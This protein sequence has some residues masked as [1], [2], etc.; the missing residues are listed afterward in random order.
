ML[1][2]Q[3]VRSVYRASQGVDGDLPVL[4]PDFIG[5]MDFR[6]VPSDYRAHEY[7]HRLKASSSAKE[8][9]RHYVNV[10]HHCGLP[11][12]CWIVDPNAH[13]FVDVHL[14]IDGIPDR[15]PVVMVRNVGRM[16]PHDD[17]HQF[18]SLLTER[19]TAIRLA[20]GGN[21][22]A[23]AKFSNVGGMIA[24]GTRIAM[25]KGEST[26]FPAVHNK[27]PY[28]A[29]LSVGED[30]IHG[31]VVDLADI[32]SHCFPQVYSVTR[33]MEVNSGVSPVAP[34]D[35]VA[36]DRDGNGDNGDDDSDNADANADGFGVGVGDDL[37]TTAH[38]WADARATL[39][40]AQ[41]TL[42]NACLDFLRRKNQE[43][44]CAV[45]AS[46]TGWV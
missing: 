31:L 7:L 41:A 13:H 12:S 23:R 22:T 45:G 29:N 24:I 39:G 36:H 43:A 19:C 35:G 9:C 25:K 40:D 33:D 18:L 2:D 6:N 37:F 34:M 17:R 11:E 15:E 3:Q 27:V 30:V 42:G 21:G 20:N 5:D 26:N 16:D 14:T 38:V 10:A 4:P 8:G 1:P 32:R 28:A 44:T 46:V